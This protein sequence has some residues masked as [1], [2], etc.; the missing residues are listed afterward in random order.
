MCTPGLD[1]VCDR[2]RTLEEHGLVVR[3]PGTI[4]EGV[5]YTLT[6]RGRHLG[7]ALALLREWGL[8]ELLPP[9]GADGGPRRYD[10][11]YAV[12]DDLSLSEHYEWIVDEDVY[13]LAIEGQE[14]TV[15]R[16]AAAQPVLVVRTTRVFLGRWVRGEAT[17]DSGRADGQVTVEGSAAAWERMLVATGYPGRPRDLVARV[18]AQRE[19]AARSAPSVRPV[20]E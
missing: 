19:P 5:A 14:L 20:L 1:A 4:R 2:L 6:A 7:P 13:T 17:W 16:G 8:E 9:S 3:T 10:M 15:Q 12:P 11:S 18:R